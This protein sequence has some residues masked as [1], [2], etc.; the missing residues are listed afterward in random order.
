MSENITLTPI[1]ITVSSFLPLLAIALGGFCFYLLYRN[2]DNLEPIHTCWAFCFATQ[3]LHFV[4]AEVVVIANIFPREVCYEYSVILFSRILMYFSIIWLQ[5]DRWAAI[6]LNSKYKGLVTNKVAVSGCF[7]A[8]VVALIVASLAS[9]IDPSYMKCTSLNE[10][11]LRATRNISVY[12][13]G[14]IRLIGVLLT[15]LVSV[16]AT[17]KKISKM[18][19]TVVVPLAPKKKDK[20]VRRAKNQVDVFYVEQTNAA[21]EAPVAT[22]IDSE[23]KQFL[24]LVKMIIKANKIPLIITVGTVWTPILGFVYAGCEEDDS[25]DGFLKK[26]KIINAMQIVFVIVE[27]VVISKNIKKF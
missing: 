24:M 8:V 17:K 26:A 11:I 15:V 21:P 9:V 22:A 27:I 2:W 19:N 12:C 16:Y 4:A 14:I 1:T 25:C 3:S 20:K 10:T 5:L 23:E 18:T 7:A 6:Y 13:D